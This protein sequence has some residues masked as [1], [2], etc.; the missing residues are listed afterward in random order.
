MTEDL[1]ILIADMI[2]SSKHTQNWELEF[3]LF[4]AYNP[5]NPQTVNHVILSIDDGVNRYYIEPTA[6]D[7]LTMLK[8]NSYDVVGWSEK[9]I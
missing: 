2:L 4:D 7:G 5:E 9:I 8:W 1:A 3:F 6:T